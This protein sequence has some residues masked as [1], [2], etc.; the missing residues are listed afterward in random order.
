MRKFVVSGEY[1]EN[2]RL[3]E[4]IILKLTCCTDV[5]WNFVAEYRT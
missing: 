4:K 2:V 3:D 1:L 5:K